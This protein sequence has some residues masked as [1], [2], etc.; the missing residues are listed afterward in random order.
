MP[1]DTSAKFFFFFLP[2][3]YFI[4][5]HKTGEIQKGL[6]LEPSLSKAFITDKGRMEMGTSPDH[7]TKAAHWARRWAGTLPSLFT[8]EKETFTK[9][10][11]KYKISYMDLILQWG[12]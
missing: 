2:N 3:K 10:L 6:G 12:T 5:Q 1:Q 7:D 9:D 8:K 11:D 4:P